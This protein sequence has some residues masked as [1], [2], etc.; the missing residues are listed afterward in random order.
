[1]LRM[2][3]VGIVGGGRVEGFGAGVQGER[4][5]RLIIGKIFCLFSYISCPLFLLLLEFWIQPQIDY[6][7]TSIG[8]A[9][10]QISADVGSGN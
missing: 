7:V 1:M 2:E 9:P 5:G 6:V 4:N 3:L 10:H 8:V